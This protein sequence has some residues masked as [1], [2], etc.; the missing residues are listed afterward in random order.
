LVAFAVDACSFA[1][2][3]GED[4]GVAGV[5]VAPAQVFVQCVGRHGVVRVIRA[6]YLEGS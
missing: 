3:G 4:V 2:L 6:G 1:A 5:R